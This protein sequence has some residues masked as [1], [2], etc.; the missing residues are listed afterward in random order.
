MVIRNMRTTKKSIEELS[1][2]RKAHYRVKGSIIPNKQYDP[3]VF[4]R[5]DAP[6]P[7]EF[8]YF[9]CGKMIIVED[10]DLTLRYMGNKCF[11]L[12]HLGNSLCSIGGNRDGP[13]MS[14]SKYS[15]PIEA[16]LVYFEAKILNDGQNR[17]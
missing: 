15:V 17:K 14:L 3:F 12:L 2:Q 4:N 10:D 5:L 1:K 6:L 13:S 8:D 11:A 9:R 16:C 7:E